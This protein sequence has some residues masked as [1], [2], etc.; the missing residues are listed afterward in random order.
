MCGGVVSLLSLSLCVCVCVCVCPCLGV[1]Q[2]SLLYLIIPTVICPYPH[3]R[4]P[5]SPLSPSPLFP[6]PSASFAVPFEE[7]LKNPDVWFLDHNYLEN[8]FAMFRKVTAK[9]RIVG[10]YSSHPTIKPNDL[11][12]NS[13]LG[14][15]C[16]NPV[17]VTVDVRPN[18][19]ELPTNAYLAVDNL[20]EGEIKKR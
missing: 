10:F 15:F 19:S 13:L 11:K 5:L 16:A 1:S 4:P 14:R 6:S 3:T 12:I 20:E 2:Q 8:M 18:Q 17:F 9:E 7:D